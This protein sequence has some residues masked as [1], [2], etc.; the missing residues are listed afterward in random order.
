[1]SFRCKI[2]YSAVLFAIALVLPV[3]LFFSAQEAGACVMYGFI[4]DDDPGYTFPEGLLYNNLVAD[5]NKTQLFGSLLYGRQSHGWGAA[6]YDRWGATLAGGD[7]H[8]YRDINKPA[9]CTWSGKTFMGCSA[10]DQDFLNMAHE[11][12]QAQPKI[13]LV[14]WR[15]GSS[16]CDGR[17]H[18]NVHPFLEDYA[19]KTW[20]FVQNGGVDKPRMKWLIV[21]GNP[22]AE[23]NDWTRNIP[24]GS[25]VEGC[26]SDRAADP[27]GDVIDKMVDSELYF[28]LVMKHIKQAHMSRRTTLE[29]IVEAISR[30]INHGETGGI[31]FLLTDG[32]TL[33]A[34]KRGNILSY[35]YNATLGFT[36]IATNQLTGFKLDPFPSGEVVLSGFNNDGWVSLKDY[37]LIICKPGVPPVVRDVRE[38]IPGN[39]TC[40]DPDNPAACDSLVDDLDR[41]ILSDALGS[42]QGDSKFVA[43]AD[44]NG[45]GCVTK[46]DEKIWKRYLDDFIMTLL[47]D[48]HMNTANGCCRDGYIR[49]KYDVVCGATYLSRSG[50]AGTITPSRDPDFFKFYAFKDQTY[51]LATDNPITD[52]FLYDT[53]GR[54]QIGAGDTLT[55]ICPAAGTYFGRVFATSTGRNY[56][57]SLSGPVYTAIDI[58]IRPCSNKNTI[59]YKRVGVIPVAILSKSGF[60]ARAVNLST[61]RLNDIPVMKGLFGHYLSLVLDVNR[62]GLKD[63]VVS[64]LNEEGA[65]HKNETEAELLG[66]L[67]DG[68]FFR[69]VDEIELAGD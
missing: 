2:R 19:G 44:L 34:F 32:Y 49:G 8:I 38:L 66:T 1:M 24:D 40:G 30:M 46:K 67:Y 22:N 41:K 42:C 62:D 7:L 27:Y 13:V 33:W 45:D 61:V 53:D 47:C 14:H 15:T 28:K 10:V 68:T 16:G 48:D 21:D 4:G 50:A 52:L 3:S 18:V 31:N 43:R 55:W 69:G 64:F 25:G 26:T 57:L 29:G 56:N 59:Y 37:E 11:L 9:D 65:F 63:L 17:T 51:T 12:D 6:R 36:D 58:D 54:T 39:L 35:R 23:N 20:S 60:D 5:F